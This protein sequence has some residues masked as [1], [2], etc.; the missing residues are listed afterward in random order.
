MATSSQRRTKDAHRH[1][2]GML[3]QPEA[4]VVQEPSSSVQHNGR[5]RTQIRVTMETDELKAMGILLC[6]LH[7]TL[8]EVTNSEVTSVDVWFLALACENYGVDPKDKDLVGWFKKW[9]KKYSTT[10]LLDSDY[11]TLVYHRQLLYPSWVF[12][13]A[14]LFAR[15]TKELVYGSEGANHL[16]PQPPAYHRSRD[17]FNRVARI[18]GSAT[19]P[20]RQ[21]MTF[22]YLREL[23]RI[24]VWP[25]EEYMPRNSISDLL[26]RLY[27]S[28]S[29]EMRP[30]TGRGRPRR[31]IAA[32]GDDVVAL[33]CES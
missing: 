29:D 20:C 1:H 31:A 7:H 9:H 6:Q 27:L 16:H 26:G 18:V 19:C 4:R 25:F 13:H 24:G 22:E 10:N 17:L 12:D 15:L 3:P 21:N 5:P 28:D 11:K 30:S 14:F 2:L 32:V 8:G 23:H 33:S